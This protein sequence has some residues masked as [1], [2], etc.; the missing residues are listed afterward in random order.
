MQAV[1]A[2]IHDAQVKQEPQKAASSIKAM[3]DE[4]D[5]KQKEIESIDS[6]FVLQEQEIVDAYNDSFL[7]SWRTISQSEDIR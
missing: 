1:A 2:Q 4:F 6:I 7:V 5:N 3:S